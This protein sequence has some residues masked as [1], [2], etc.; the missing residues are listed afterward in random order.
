MRKQGEE[1]EKLG[2]EIKDKV[3]C[4]YSLI[5]MCADEDR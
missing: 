4:K 3:N 1:T 5:S 2:L